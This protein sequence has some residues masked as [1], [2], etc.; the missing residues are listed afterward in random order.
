MS[1]NDASKIIIDDS[2]VMLQIVTSLTDNSRGI[3][4][5]HNMFMVQDTEVN[6]LKLFFSLLLLAKM[7]ER[8]NLASFPF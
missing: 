1:E 3:I 8:L 2:K 6:V 5:D 7:L 4:Y